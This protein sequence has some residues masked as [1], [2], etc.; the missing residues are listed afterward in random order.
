[1]G[2]SEKSSDKYR[3]INEALPRLRLDEHYVVDE[4]NHSATLTDDGVG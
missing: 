1:M 4:K 2:Q 3:I